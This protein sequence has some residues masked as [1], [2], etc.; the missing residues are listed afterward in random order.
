M[1]IR[2]EGRLRPLV[3]PRRAMGEGR[4]EKSFRCDRG[5]DRIVAAFTPTPT[6]DSSS[7]NAVLW[8]Q[9]CLN[10]AFPNHFSP[11]SYGCSSCNTS[12]A[13]GQYFFRERWK[14]W[15]E[16]RVATGR[17]LLGLLGGLPLACTINHCSTGRTHSVLRNILTR[18]QEWLFTGVVSG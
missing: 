12:D 11:S 5:P 9:P 6:A 7:V 17:G 13:G 15:L 4:R 1:R 3:P 10:L 14:P 8:L 18:C 2:V 16:P